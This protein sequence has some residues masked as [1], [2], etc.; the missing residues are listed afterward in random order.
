MF[1]VVEGHGFV[2]SRR[3]RRLIEAAEEADRIGHRR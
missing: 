1:V 2:R 3:G